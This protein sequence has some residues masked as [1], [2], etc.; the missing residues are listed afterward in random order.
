ML[1]IFALFGYVAAAGVGLL[2][3]G[4]LFLGKSHAIQAK[5]LTFASLVNVGW[6]AM[7]AW[8]IRFAEFGPMLALS[9]EVIRYWAW[10]I[11]LISVLGLAGSQALSKTLRGAAYFAPGIILIYGILPESI[12]G[13]PATIYV[14][15][16]IA[17]GLLAL[18]TLERIYRNVDPAARG[19]I[20]Y[21]TLAIGGMFGYDLVI[22]EEKKIFER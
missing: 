13:G 20:G 12:G 14:N 2:L 18:V 21:L 7:M 4:L 8:Q 22:Q 17:L 15:G 10:L 9:I 6:S 1:G 11:F 19:P 16:S 5:L 3:A